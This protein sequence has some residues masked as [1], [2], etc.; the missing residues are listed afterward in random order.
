MISTFKS[1]TILGPRSGVSYSGV[2]GRTLCY[3]VA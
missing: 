1:A 3:I 2:L